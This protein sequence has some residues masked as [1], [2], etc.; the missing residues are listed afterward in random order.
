[1]LPC[2]L[3]TMLPRFCTTEGDETDDKWGGER[4]KFLL[5]FFGQVPSLLQHSA[6]E[7]DL[8]ANVFA[9]VFACTHVHQLNLFQQLNLSVF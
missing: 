1:M 6:T 4:K 2:S 9:H 7:G 8:H 5:L 3:K